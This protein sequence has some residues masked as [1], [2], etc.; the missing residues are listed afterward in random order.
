MQQT[1]V[2]G[3]IILVSL[4]VFLPL[5]VLY[6]SRRRQDEYLAS[7]YKSCDFMRD[8][9]HSCSSRAEVLELTDDLASVRESYD[10]LIPTSVL[11]K[12]LSLLATL[13]SKKSKKIK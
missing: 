7:F 8:D 12:E 1:F 11:D 4:A 5:I 6:M 3:F 10:S 13:L 9:I 2:L